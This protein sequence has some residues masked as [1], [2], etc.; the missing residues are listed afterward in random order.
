VLCALA[1][2][3]SLDSPPRRLS[4]Y[5]DN[6]NSVQIFNSLKALGPYN[7]ILL[8]LARILLQSRIDLRGFHVAGELNVI[9][10]ALS[11]GLLDIACSHAPGLR[12]FRL[13]PPRVALGAVA[14]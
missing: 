8:V 1:W 2:A 12:I 10:N 3:A 4:I 9:A 7:D 14:C 5:T 11:R 6:L 13:Q